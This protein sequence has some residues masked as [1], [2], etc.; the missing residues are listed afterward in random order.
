MPHLIEPFR[1]QKISKV[2]ERLRDCHRFLVSRV[3]ASATSA[4]ERAT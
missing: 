2:V 1:N 3:V 4:A